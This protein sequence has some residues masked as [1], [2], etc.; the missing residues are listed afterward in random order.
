MYSGNTKVEVKSDLCN[1][2][3][4]DTA[5]VYIQ[6][7][8]HNNYA[9]VNRDTTGNTRPLNTGDTGDEKCKIFDMAVNCFEWTTEYCIITGNN[10]ALPCSFRSGKYD[11][12][13]Y[14]SYRDYNNVESK[15]IGLSF[16]PLLYI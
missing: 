11:G 10:Y 4:W 7:M 2:Y 1:S 6:A 9:N 16:R 3:G 8:G 12:D 5:I 15:N 13:K 14:T